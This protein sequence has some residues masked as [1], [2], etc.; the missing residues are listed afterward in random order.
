MK[1][2]LALVLAL[3]M[4]VSFAV[5]CDKK[6]DDKTPTETPDA[7]TKL[8]LKMGTNAEFPPYEY[9]ENGVIVG[10]DAEIAKAIADKLGMEL[11]IVDMKFDAILASVQSGGVD[12]GVAGMTIT[13]ERLESVN[14]SVSYATGVQVVIV[15][16]DSDI[17]SP[18][19]LAGKKIG[20]QLATTGDIYAS[21]DFGE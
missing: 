19:D 14:F 2:V 8:T 16:A 1:K 21:D 20:V 3:L 12:M 10:I 4:I 15:K 5:A 13:D 6:D 9:Y 11:E 7:G 18:D 17:A